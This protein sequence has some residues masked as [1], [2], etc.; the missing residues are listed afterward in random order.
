VDATVGGSAGAIDDMAR[1][2]AE[3]AVAARP[4]SATARTC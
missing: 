3:Q 2:V 4:I 1:I